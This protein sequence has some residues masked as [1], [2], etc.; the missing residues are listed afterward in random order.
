MIIRVC[1]VDP[2]PRDPRDD[3]VT[4]QVPERSR[5]YELLVEVLEAQ[6]LE[7]I[8]IESTRRCKEEDKKE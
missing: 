4:F 1:V 6:G 2:S 5:A 7:F 8:T 3:V